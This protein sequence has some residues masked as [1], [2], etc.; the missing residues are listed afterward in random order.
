MAFTYRIQKSGNVEGTR[1]Q[2]VGDVQHIVD[3]KYLCTIRRVLLTT[4]IR[5][6]RPR[7]TEPGARESRDSMGTRRI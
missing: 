6:A 4:C 3:S 2:K 7:R 1:T 5:L